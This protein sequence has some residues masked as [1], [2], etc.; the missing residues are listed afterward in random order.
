[1]SRSATSQHG[2]CTDGGAPVRDALPASLSPEA[3][4]WIRRRLDV[5]E[6]KY[7]AVLRVGWSR[8]REAI[9]EELADGVAYAVAAGDAGLADALGAMLSREV[10]R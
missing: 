9:A 10:G 1:M 2:P 6:A 8:A 4:A 3:A 5:G 7:G